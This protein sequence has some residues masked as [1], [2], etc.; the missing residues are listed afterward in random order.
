MPLTSTFTIQGRTLFKKIP[1]QYSIFLAGNDISTHES[2]SDGNSEHNSSAD[3]DSQ[4]R[5]R[6]K[7]KLQRNRTSFTNDQIDSL[8]K[9]ES[10]NSYFRKIK[11]YRF[12]RKTIPALFQRQINQKSLTPSPVPALDSEGQIG[13]GPLMKRTI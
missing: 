3:E 9:G 10:S 13:K 12:Q 5:L 8:E 4:L 6:L 11:L 7:R 1:N 2:A